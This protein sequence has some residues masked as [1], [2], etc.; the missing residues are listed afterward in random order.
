MSWG[1]VMRYDP[2]REALYTP[3]RQYPRFPPDMEWTLD[4]LCAEFSRKAYFHFEENAGEERLSAELAERGFTNVKCFSK[5]RGWSIGAQAF[6]AVSPDNGV[7]VAFRGTQWNEPFDA[8]GDLRAL[9]LSWERG[10]PGR[11]HRGFWRQLLSLLD[12]LDP[13]IA[14]H[15]NVPLC[16]TGH[17]LGAALAT[18]MAARYPSS[19]LVTFGSPEVGNRAFAALI[20]KANVRRYV[21][22]ADIVT[23]VPFWWPYVPVGERIYIDRDGKLH[24]TASAASV[25]ADRE[26]A[27]AEYS[28]HYR[29][30]WTNV[31]IRR[32]AD[33]API[34]YVSALLGI[35]TP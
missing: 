21:D 4:R 14:E 1:L 17:S 26:I 29:N 12:Q 18:L 30:I 2:T 16:F 9:L 27:I 34:N 19:R 25:A 35:R 6:G 11:V 5:K 32:L 33:H 10:R 31:L 28:E 15:R 3:E 24:E 13:W 8:I 23:M 7:V 22:C 20:D